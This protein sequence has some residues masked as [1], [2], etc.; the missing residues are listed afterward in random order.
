MYRKNG[1]CHRGESQLHTGDLSMNAQKRY[2]AI[3]E[4]LLI[5]PAALFMAALVLRQLTASSLGVAAQLTVM[6][7]AERQWTL[8]L[9]LVTLPLAVVVA[10]CATLLHVWKY[11]HSRT[12]LQQTVAA[13]LTDGTSMLIA[14]LT[15]V[16][17]IF[18]AVVGLHILAN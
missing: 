14:V 15:I 6:W 12:G 13:V 10:G 5:L 17:A 8:W 2:V 9:L 7:Y 1:V 3:M 18:L 16:A 4:V 11:E